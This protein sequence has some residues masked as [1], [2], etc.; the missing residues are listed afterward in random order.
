[1]TR[2]TH[3]AVAVALAFCQTAC[4]KAGLIKGGAAAAPLAYRTRDQPAR[5]PGG[6]ISTSAAR[7]LAD[8][9]HRK[10]VQSCTTEHHGEFDLHVFE[11]GDN[12]ERHRDGEAARMLQQIRAA[13]EKDG[14]I[15]LTFVHGWQHSADVCD[16]NLVCFRQSLAAL[17]Q[18]ENLL[19]PLTPRRIVGV[20]IG[21]RGYESVRVEGYRRVDFLSR[22]AAAQR[23]GKRGGRFLLEQLD[24]IRRDN[25]G[26]LMINIGHSYG[27]ALLFAGIQEALE[28]SISQSAKEGSVIRGLGDL[29]VLLNPAFQASRY[30]E[31]HR[32]S[33]R[34][35]YHPRQGPVLLTVTTRNDWVTG[36][37]FRIPRQV[38]FPL[39]ASR[40]PSAT[41]ASFWTALG[42]FEP[43]R[44]HTLEAT[45]DRDP[46]DTKSPPIT[47]YL[48]RSKCECEVP[49]MRL[50]M[51]DMM[52]IA[53]S[54]SQ[55]S[56][57]GPVD[58][59]PARLFPHR[60]IPALVDN[61]PFLNVYADTGENKALLGKP[62]TLMYGHGD[63]FN[64]LVFRFV[65]RFVAETASDLDSGR[66]SP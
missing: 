47:L 45:V 61:V 49:P 44:S 35:S 39:A 62:K 55:R 22:M 20:Y 9:A 3:F 21:W 6:A 29:S 65:A 7:I 17:S 60:S 53:S 32:A 23:I 19:N 37:A 24:A 25:D 46:G 57:A 51:L 34:R 52:A 18:Y 40:P 31:V 28:K 59:G 43:Y 66:K 48:S 2:P 30:Q 54:G 11:F 26:S 27:G 56:T 58:F 10:A 1:M 13:A 63:I 12:G 36:I 14:A 41:R 16:Q 5:G 38:L 15:I 33:L 64:S 42:Q 4:T 50:A 8:H